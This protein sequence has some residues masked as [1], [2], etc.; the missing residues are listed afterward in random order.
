MAVQVATSGMRRISC[1]VDQLCY[2]ADVGVDGITTVDIPAV[3]A[4]SATSLANGTVLA[5]AGNVVPTAVM[6]DFI[7][8]RYGRNISVTAGAGGAGVIVG[9]DYLG[10][11]IKENVTLIAGAVL[12]K[13]M[14]KDIGSQW[15]YL[16]FKDAHHPETWNP[17]M[18]LVEETSMTHAPEVDLFP[19]WLR[20][21]TRLS[22]KFK[23]SARHGRILRY[24]F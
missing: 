21:A 24:A 19:T 11:A 7:M 17:R 5:A 23:A 10:Q 3:A 18:R 14:F 15:G 6:T 20:I 2:A 4:A 13:K 12:S 8:G 16:G 1:R 22:G 9:Y